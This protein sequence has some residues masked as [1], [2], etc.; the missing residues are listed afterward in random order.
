MQVLELPQSENF[1]TSFYDFFERS[2]CEFRDSWGSAKSYVT[3][4]RAPDFYVMQKDLEELCIM[5]ALE[6][7]TTREMAEK[8]VK[9]WTDKLTEDNRFMRIQMKAYDDC[10]DRIGEPNFTVEEDQVDLL[11]TNFLEAEKTRLKSY[12]MYCGCRYASSK[13]C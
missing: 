11:E 2:W 8:S 9:F 10:I 3:Q 1:E 6:K 7:I 5:H 13:F 4:T 12:L